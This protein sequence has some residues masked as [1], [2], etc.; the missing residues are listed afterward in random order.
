MLL[1]VVTCRLQNLYSR[2]RRNSR[3]RCSY[4]FCERRYFMMEGRF[5]RAREIFLT[6]LELD[7]NNADILYNFGYLY[8]I[9]EK[10]TRALRYYTQAWNAANNDESLRNDVQSAISRIWNE[11]IPSFRRREF[12]KRV[13]WARTAQPQKLVQG[14]PKDNIHVVYTMAH[15]CNRWC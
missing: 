8:E 4:M 13:L 14:E 11:T 7:P 10:P 5:D 2:I 3:F 1:V 9:T 6:G 12:E 15:G